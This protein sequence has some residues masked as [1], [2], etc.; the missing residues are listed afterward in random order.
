MYHEG[1][2]VYQLCE[3]VRWGVYQPDIGCVSRLWSNFFQ[4]ECV[5]PPP[6]VPEEQRAWS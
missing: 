3:T 2:T 4:P 1:E 5:L 6:P